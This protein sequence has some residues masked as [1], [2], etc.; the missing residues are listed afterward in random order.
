MITASAAQ[1][2]LLARIEELERENAT[3]REHIQVLQGKLY[4]AVQPLSDRSA[5]ARTLVQA[6]DAFLL[7]FDRSYLSTGEVADWDE[8]F[9]LRHI[10]RE[11]TLKPCP[12]NVTGP[13]SRKSPCTCEPICGWPC[14]PSEFCRRGHEREAARQGT[15]RGGEIPADLIKR[16]EDAPNPPL[17]GD[18]AK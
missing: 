12:T 3:A 11:E 9:D 17:P 18:T 14:K 4:A 10:W 5:P 2:T 1:L 8:L 7:R 15:A 16:I 6:V 13:D